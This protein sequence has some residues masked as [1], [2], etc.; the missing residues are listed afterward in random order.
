LINGC[1]RI[2]AVF[3]TTKLVE[4]CMV[5]RVVIEQ[6]STAAWLPYLWD[7]PRRLWATFPHQVIG[8]CA[9]QVLTVPELSRVRHL[10][11]NAFADDPLMRWIFPGDTLRPHAIAMMLGLFIE[12]YAKA[13][14]VD[15]AL[16]TTEERGDGDV[17]GQGQRYGRSEA[18]TIIGAAHWR[19]PDAALDPS[20]LPSVGGVLQSVLGPERAAAVG[21]A[22]G[23]FGERRPAQPHAYLHIL[24]IDPS[25]HGRGHGRRLLMHGLEEASKLGLGTHLETTKER[26]VA[27]YR[28]AGFEVTG[29]VVLGDDGPATWF[30]WREPM[31]GRFGRSG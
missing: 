9:M 24:A 5:V 13:G 16:A 26:N 8:E 7:A 3:C 22:L 14:T 11:T 4:M 6:V 25:H 30:M 17:D 15:L 28:S 23:V 12:S 2:I 27:F 29:Q 10:V 18:D 20:K 31:S 21:R 19:F 1:G